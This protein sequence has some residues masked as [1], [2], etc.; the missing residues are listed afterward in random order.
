MI[1]NSN[2][3]T[4]SNKTNKTNNNNNKEKNQIANRKYRIQI[5][6]SK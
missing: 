1:I 5:K 3:S 6:E 2:N 4:K